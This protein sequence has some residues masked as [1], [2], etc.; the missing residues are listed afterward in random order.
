MTQ[1][2][3]RPSALSRRY[4]FFAGSL[5][6]LLAIMAL[7]APVSADCGDGLLDAEEICDD[8]NLS[9]ADCCS[10]TCDLIS[11]P[12]TTESPFRWEAIGP[13]DIGGRVTA[14]A[15]DARDS[16]QILVGTVAS[17]VW[18]SYDRGLSW[19][20]IA[21][22]L[23][24]VEVGA[25][26]IDP[27]DSDVYL[28]GTGRLADSG[29]PNDGLG[30]MRTPSG[31][32]DWTYQADGAATAHIADILIWDTEP[33]RVITAT[34]RGLR[35]SLDG[36][37]SFAAISSGDSFSTVVQD[38][39]DSETVYASGRSGLYKS[40]Q[41]GATWN[42]ISEW[43]SLT[44][45]DI[46]VAT[47]ALALSMQTPGK[48]LVVAQVLATFDDTD[49]ILLFSSMDGGETLSG[50]PTPEGLCPVSNL[51][52]FANAVAL[53]PLDDTRILL[54]GDHLFLSNDDGETFSSYGPEIRGVNELAVN[55]DGVVVVGR[56]GVALLDANWDFEGE[57]NE[58]LPI[59][60]IVSLDIISDPD[61]RVLI[62][63]RDHGTLLTSSEEIDWEVIFGQ[64]EMA[65]VARFD[66][67]DANVLYASKTY[68]D[69]QRS[70]DGGE[71][72]F[73]ATAGLSPTQ[74]AARVAPLSPNPLIP[75]HLYTGR[76]QLFETHDR[77]DLWEEFR[78]L[79]APEISLIEASPADDDRVFFSIAGGST[80]F[81]ADNIHTYGD[82]LSSNLDDE[83]TTIWPDREFGH[84]IYTT[85][86]NHST[87]TGVMLRTTD[88]GVTWDD[89]NWTTLPSIWD[90]AKDENGTL[91]V[92]TSDG[93]YRSPSDGFTWSRFNAGIP[94]NAISRLAIGDGTVYA[95]SKGHGVF[96]LNAEVLSTIDTIPSGQKVL[97]DGVLHQGPI[98]QEWAEGSEHTIAPYLLQTAD[99]R[100]EFVAWLDGGAAE[101]TVTATGDNDW[102]ILGVKVL[103][104]LSTLT[105]PSEGGHLLLEPSSEDGFYPLESIVQI[106][107]IPEPDYKLVGFEGDTSGVDLLLALALM[108]KPRS[109]EAHFEPLMITLRTSPPGIELMVDGSTE[110]TPASFQWAMGSVH[111]VSAPEMTDDNPSDAVEMRFHAWN[112]Y[113]PREH[114]YVMRRDMFTPDRVAHYIPTVSVL[115]VPN[116]A[117]RVIRTQ[118]TNHPLTE[119][120][121]TFE[122]SLGEELP[123]T[124]QIARSTV[125]N[126]LVTEFVLPQAVLQ[127]EVSSYIEGRRLTEGGGLEGTQRIRRTRLSVFNPGDEEAS[128]SLALRDH[129]G[130]PIAG[131]TDLIT[132]PAGG[133]RVVSVDETL[134][135]EQ[136][137]EGLLTVQSDQPVAVNILLVGE[138]L[139]HFDF[140]DPILLQIFDRSGEDIPTEIRTQALLATPD[141]THR[142]VLANSGGSTL[143]GQFRF[144]DATGADLEIE[145]DGTTAAS[146][147]YS[148][149]AGGFE[150]ITFQLSENLAGDEDIRHARL[151]VIPDGESGS[152]EI[153]HLA[154]RVVGPSRYGDLLLPHSIPPSRTMENF[155]L[156]VE[157]AMRDTRAVMTNRSGID[158]LV[159]LLLHNETGAPFVGT[160]MILPAEGQSLV[161]TRAL[162]PETQED[163]RGFL[164]VISSQSIDVA[165]VF[166][167][168]N[169]RD[170]M[171]ISG[172]P[173]LARDITEASEAQHYGYAVDGD[174]WASEWWFLNEA[175]GARNVSVTYRRA[176]GTRRYLPMAE[177]VAEAP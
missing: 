112:D 76:L 158:S 130:V 164:S 74:I 126:E 29:E 173:V 174:T 31:G 86:T 109:V 68:G 145:H 177:P 111:S 96:R 151:E 44:E 82:V 67:F 58:S 85:L 90:F 34:D 141:T 51:C 132:V 63:T 7:Q 106:L 117:I 1:V 35:L 147:A 139:R 22:W 156:P 39:F 155:T 16:D 140:T 99:E 133:R 92:A 150:R 20:A 73:P 123:R 98:Y 105:D 122:P 115:P 87:Q 66:P 136:N 108:D 36:G 167:A 143:T 25:L 131:D 146:H 70:D 42:L 159:I 129:E 116:G 33:E 61:D 91:Y 170:E 114:D 169:G 113:K 43:P 10:D 41:R 135:L 40:S 124:L 19:V 176:N 103:Y 55:E 56:S 121:A 162:F 120:S 77:G 142:V 46:G 65:G 163:Q 47:T 18:R 4:R 80:L 13:F 118:G 100:Q 60:G 160:A 53:H 101:H 119:L 75:G 97:I 54:G 50:I 72:F 52:G 172:F 26:A 15:V 138:N 104:R 8:G 5:A 32:L 134:G 69:I 12:E 88:F 11:C 166:S 49:R 175:A 95:G 152:P 2:N 57:R 168:T 144:R 137:Y 154:D 127:T 14:V 37:K 157:L 161:S 125:D 9:N 78:P 3:R 24:V 38:P 23:D 64:R 93:V 149:E 153:F 83:I 48:L 107:A 59:T 165:G 6:V 148:L 21:P 110:A 28:V 71:T 89:R 84:T 81:K 94:T 79:G 17:G 27:S 45:D 128:I 102:N 171:I 62:G 30:I